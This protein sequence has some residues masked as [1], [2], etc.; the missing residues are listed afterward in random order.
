MKVLF[1][2]IPKVDNK[3]QVLCKIDEESKTV[4]VFIDCK[5]DEAVVKFHKTIHALGTGYRGYHIVA[6]PIA[7]NR[8]V[9][10]QLDARIH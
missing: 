10:I 1:N 9:K 8:D 7:I 2:D 6:K 3:S 5:I 4:T